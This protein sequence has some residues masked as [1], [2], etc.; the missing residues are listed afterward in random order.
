MLM[1]YFQIYR[2]HV[3]NRGG[4]SEPI[5]VHWGGHVIA[6]VFLSSKDAI[7]SGRCATLFSGESGVYIL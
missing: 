2:K 3:R 7:A 4:A 6:S 1:S 5:L